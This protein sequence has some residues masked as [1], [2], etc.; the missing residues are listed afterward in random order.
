MNWKLFCIDTGYKRL[1]NDKCKKLLQAHRTA[2][3]KDDLSGIAIQPG[4]AQHFMT[5]GGIDFVAA[6]KGL[7][8]RSRTAFR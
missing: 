8:F 1:Y 5:N 4:M 2:L 7:N 3:I 6:E